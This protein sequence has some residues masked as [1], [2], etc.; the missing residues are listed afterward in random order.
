MLRTFRDKSCIPH[1]SL[2]VPFKFFISNT[3]KRSSGNWE[4]P[5]QFSEFI[6]NFTNCWHTG[7][8]LTLWINCYLPLPMAH[9]RFPGNDEVENLAE[10]ATFLAFIILSFPS[11]ISI[12]LSDTFYQKSYWQLPLSLCVTLYNHSILIAYGFLTPSVPHKQ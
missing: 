7:D 9:W 5:L 11:R 3:L 1:P 4:F 8:F 10:S 12:P 2:S 6:H